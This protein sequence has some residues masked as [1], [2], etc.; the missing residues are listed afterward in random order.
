[1]GQ[2]SQIKR[3]PRRVEDPTPDEI[4]RRCLEIQLT[5]SER[6]RLARQLLMVFTLDELDEGSAPVPTASQR[7]FF[8]N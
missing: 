6:Q 3:N 7:D 4:Q 8:K 5:W 1:M 2:P